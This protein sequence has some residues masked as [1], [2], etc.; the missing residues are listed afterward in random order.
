MFSPLRL[1]VAR[2]RCSP[3]NSVFPPRGCT[4]AGHRLRNSPPP[5]VI[6]SSSDTVTISFMTCRKQ[7]TLS[8]Y[9]TWTR[10]NAPSRM[11]KRSLAGS[12]HLAFD[13]CATLWGGGMR[14]N[15]ASPPDIASTT[16]RGR[17]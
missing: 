4:F 16:S 5:P 17:Y 8:I 12:Q 3:A 9:H 6:A 10:E 15:P 14:S 7:A 11:K 2:G 1:K 13:N